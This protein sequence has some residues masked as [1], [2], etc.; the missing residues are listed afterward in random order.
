M[1]DL[2]DSEIVL[3][4]WAESPLKET[5]VGTPITLTFFKPEI[6]AGPVETSATFRFAGRV[7]LAGPAA[8]PDLTP[9]FPGI[10][11]KLAIG[12]WNPPFP[13]DKSRIKPR[14]ENERYWDK[15]RATPKAYITLAAAEKLFGSRFGVT[16]SIRVAPAAGE[17]ADQAADRLRTAVRTKLAPDTFGVAFEA[18][19]GSGCSPRA[20]VAPTSAGCSSGS[21]SS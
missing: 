10:T 20:A 16:T 3:A 12:D 15:H 19:R 13:F 18:D 8:D 2:N 17:S 9:P 1:T 5:P 11:D 6:E 4:D 7:P 14:D 21:A